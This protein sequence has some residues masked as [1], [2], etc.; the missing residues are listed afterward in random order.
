MTA[1]SDQQ[2]PALTGIRFL[3]ALWV[4]GQHLTGPQ[5]RLG[6]QALRLPYPI[7]RIIRGGDLAVDI[8]FM[9]SGFLLARG[10]ASTRWSG[11]KLRQYFLGRFARVYPVYLLSLVLVAPFIAADWKPDTGR[12]LADYILLL[13]GW[14]GTMPVNW[15]TPAWTL[16]CE[17]FFYLV[18]PVAVF[19]IRR[20]RW[21]TVILYSAAACTMT[22]VA[23]TVGLPDSV[24]PLVHFSDFLMGIG[25]AGA[26]G[27]LQRRSERPPGSWL[28]LP[29]FAVIGMLIVW[30][31]LLPWGIDLNSALKPLNGIL[32][33]GL[34]LGG[35]VVAR[36]LSSE[37]VVYLGKSSYAMY[38]LHVPIMWWCWR[39]GE[40]N[41]VLYAAVVVAVSA[42]VYGLYEEPANRWMRGRDRRKRR[43]ETGVAPTPLS[44]GSSA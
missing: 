43:P 4:I 27:L 44:A 14:I 6:I 3:L 40:M 7:Y 34:A 9:L 29:G 1:R 36:G 22:R 24:Q 26:F 41:P 13:Q 2:L 35:G 33:I 31:N 30:P 37:L 21:R 10:Y 23:R 25:A 15:N 20:P 42:L 32:L 38:I 5:Q 28:Y 16:S 12:Y 8:F 18:F 17:I 11:P 19:P 39:R